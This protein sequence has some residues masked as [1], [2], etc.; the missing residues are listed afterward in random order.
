M[1]FAF[2]LHTRGFIGIKQQQKQYAKSTCVYCKYQVLTRKQVTEYSCLFLLAD[3]KA[4]TV[5]DN[6]PAL[7]SNGYQNF[8]KNFPLCQ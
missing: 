7:L 2:I 4:P 6:A 8:S 3:H 5:M 1:C